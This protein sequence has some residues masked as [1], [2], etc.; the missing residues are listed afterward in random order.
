MKDDLSP[1]D[2]SGMRAPSGEFFFDTAV[3]QPPEL[4]NALFRALGQPGIII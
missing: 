3:P 2:K 4:N 1:K